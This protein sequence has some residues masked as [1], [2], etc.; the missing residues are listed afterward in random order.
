MAKVHFMKKTFFMLLSIQ[1]F[2]LWCRGHLCVKSLVDRLHP[3]PKYLGYHLTLKT[4][5]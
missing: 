2:A 5:L 4:G 3:N 1:L